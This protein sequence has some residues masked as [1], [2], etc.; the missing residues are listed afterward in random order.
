MVYTKYKFTPW[1]IARYLIILNSSRPRENEIISD[2]FQNH[3]NEIVWD[4]RK[5]FNKFRN[6]VYNLMIILSARPYE[7]VEI[8]K[9]LK[10]LKIKTNDYKLDKYGTYF[11]LKKLKILYSEKS[12]CSINF[13]IMIN[14]LGYKRR[15]SILIE[16]IL[17]AVNALHLQF[18]LKQYTPCDIARIK[19]NQTVIIRVSDIY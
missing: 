11:K 18:Y 5:D 15:N 4:Y 9:T 14:E 1:D 7:L 17:R 12:Y 13:E 10:D 8:Q 6:E 3:N 16:N 2:F 19:L